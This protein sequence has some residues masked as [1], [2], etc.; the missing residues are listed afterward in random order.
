MFIAK[1]TISSVQPHQTSKY[2]SQNQEIGQA[3]E[4]RSELPRMEAVVAETGFWKN[5]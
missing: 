5:R 4:S 3:F 2:K 1:K